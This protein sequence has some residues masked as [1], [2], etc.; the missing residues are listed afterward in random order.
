[1]ANNGSSSKRNYKLLTQKGKRNFSFNQ[2]PHV[3][4]MAKTQHEGGFLPH[5]GEFEEFAE[6]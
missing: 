5:G 3:N 4:A 2:S 6:T 1:M